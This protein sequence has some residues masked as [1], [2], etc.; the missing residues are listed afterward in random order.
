MDRNGTV[1]PQA[2]QDYLTQREHGTP[3]EEQAMSYPNELWQERMCL[4]LRE[5]TES[6]LVYVLPPW[7]SDYKK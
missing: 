1:K 3:V 4:F 2:S 6:G 7:L 5:V